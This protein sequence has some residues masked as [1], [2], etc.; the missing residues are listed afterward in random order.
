[1]CKIYKYNLTNK[2]SRLHFLEI[3]H[4]YIHIYIRKKGTGGVLHILLLI[5]GKK[6]NAGQLGKNGIKKSRCRVLRWVWNIKGPFFQRATDDCEQHIAACAPSG[7][8]SH[9]HNGTD[10]SCDHHRLCNTEYLHHFLSLASR[11]F[12]QQIQHREKLNQGP[13]TGCKNTFSVKDD[14]GIDQH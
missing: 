13:L 3:V 14:V 1:M 12:T 11:G 6:D 7:S 9:S 4:I 5:K 2:S 8:D 10:H